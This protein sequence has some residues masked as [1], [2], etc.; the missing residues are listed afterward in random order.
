[1]SNDITNALIDLV[2]AVTTIFGG[3]L[4]AYVRRH[5]SAATIDT[6]EQIARIAVGATEQMAKTAGWDSGQKLRSA[7]QDVR[8]LG[9]KHGIRFSDEQWRTLIERQVREMQRLDAALHPSPPDSTPEII[10]PPAHT[11][12]PTPAE[13]AT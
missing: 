2:L 11:P 3:M 12:P 13:P 5:A 7:L 1:M 4:V 9:E 8:A 6:A 10:V